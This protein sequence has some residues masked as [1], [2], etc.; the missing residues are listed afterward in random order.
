[1]KKKRMRMKKKHGVTSHLDFE[2]LLIFK[3]L[4]K[5]IKAKTTPVI[6]KPNM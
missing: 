5:M 6:V 1:M 2:E 4:N 3:K